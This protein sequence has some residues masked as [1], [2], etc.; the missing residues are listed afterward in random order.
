MSIY[1]V[2]QSPTSTHMEEAEMLIIWAQKQM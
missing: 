1:L 2:Q